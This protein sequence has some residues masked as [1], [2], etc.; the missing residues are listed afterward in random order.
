M[1]IVLKE[2]GKKDILKRATFLK[3]PITKEQLNGNLEVVK[4]Y[5]SSNDYLITIPKCFQ[6][7]AISKNLCL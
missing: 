1:S 4:I 5:P 3:L 7:M 6:K 2:E